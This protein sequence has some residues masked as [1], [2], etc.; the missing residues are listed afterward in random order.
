VYFVQQYYPT[1]DDTFDVQ[2]DGTERPKEI[3]TFHDTAGI[4]TPTQEIR[5]CY[6]QVNNTK[7]LFSYICHIRLLMHFYWFMMQMI[8][9]H[10]NVLK[11]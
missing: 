10:L 9:S 7:Q 6:L 2:M 3:I 4:D 11:D 5:K 8:C 1:I